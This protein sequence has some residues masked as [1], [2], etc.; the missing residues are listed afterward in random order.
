MSSATLFA[1]LTQ[2]ERSFLLAP[3]GTVEGGLSAAALAAAAVWTTRE[4]GSVATLDSMC[5]GGSYLSPPGELP[6]DALS[7]DLSHLVRWRVSL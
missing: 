4:T 2:Q 7:I 3:P 5:P 1:G 6:G